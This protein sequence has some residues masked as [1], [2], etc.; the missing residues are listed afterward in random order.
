MQKLDA[1]LR[2][3]G[4]KIQG[5]AKEG[6]VQTSKMKIVASDLEQIQ[7]QI[8]TYQVIKTENLIDTQPDFSIKF[9]SVSVESKITDTTE[10]EVNE[11]HEAE[12]Q[13]ASPQSGLFSTLCSSSAAPKPF[14]TKMQS[15]KKKKNDDSDS[16]ACSEEDSDSSCSHID[17]SYDVDRMASDGDNILY[18]TYND[19]KTDRIAYCCV[20][21]DDDNED[22]YRHWNYA[23]IV[24]MIWWNGIRKFVCATKTGI[25]TVEYARKK[26]RID[27]AIRSKWSHVRVAENSTQLCAWIR[28]AKNDFH[29]IEI[30]SP[31][32]ELMRTIDF[33]KYRNETF[34]NDSISFC[35]TDDLIASLCS[36]TQNNRK[37][38]EVT[39]CD[40]QLKKS[41]SITLDDCNRCTEI[42]TNGKNQFFITTGRRSFHIVSPEHLI[43]TVELENNGRWIAI[44]DD[45]QVG[46][47]DGR[48]DIQLVSYPTTLS[49]LVALWK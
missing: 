3:I 9:D 30:Y 43:Q 20:D 44:M 32:F 46:V 8:S 18:T 2:A 12:P 14:V 1:N 15:T 45:E 19:S 10:M 27:E 41:N 26:F 35:V 23:R 48:C 38:L 5:L 34:L 40:F 16:S 29:G 25:Y 33:A 37:I 13:K 39:F 24:D 42:R 17:T 11:P 31:Q 22:D 6:S 49:G 4:G 21:D 28:S 7:Q 47:S 36:R